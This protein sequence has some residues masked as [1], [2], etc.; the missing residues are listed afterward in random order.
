MTGVG[1]PGASEVE[2]VLQSRSFLAPRRPYRPRLLSATCTLD[3][4]PSSVIQAV[5]TWLPLQWVLVTCKRW[6]PLAIRAPCCPACHLHVII[7]PCSPSP[8]PTRQSHTCMLLQGTP[9][10]PKHPVCGQRI[11][12]L[13]LQQT[14]CLALRSAPPGFLGA[15][16]PS[17]L[18]LLTPPSFSSHSCLP[19]PSTQTI[20]P[21]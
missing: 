8:A 20:L 4:L 6:S 19:H 16:P 21:S 17:T 12:P 1:D 13:S 5:P 9:A 10:F 11:S 14:P 7:F 3:P 2:A 15:C 18:P